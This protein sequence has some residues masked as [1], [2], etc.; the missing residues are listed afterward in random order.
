MSRKSREAREAKEV[1][2]KKLFE[3][4]IRECVD[5]YRKKLVVPKKIKDRFTYKYNKD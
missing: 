1:L 3:L 4:H 2:K 5:P